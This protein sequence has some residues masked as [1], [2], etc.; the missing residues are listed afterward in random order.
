MAGMKKLKAT[1]S[2]FSS[3]PS[4][5]RSAPTRYGCQRRRLDGRSALMMAS[6]RARLY[7]GLAAIILLTGLAAGGTAFRW[8]YYEAIEFQDAVLLQ[9]GTLAVDNHMRGGPT[10]EHGI[11]AEARVIIEELGQSPLDVDAGLPR[12]PN[13]IPDGLQT[14]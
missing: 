2:S 10:V 7:V 11:D 5:R 9:I 6:L 4:A 12:L 13:N 8:A 14:L 3:M 1:R